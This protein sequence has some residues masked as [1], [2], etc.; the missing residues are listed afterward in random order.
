MTLT[1]GQFH[2]KLEAATVD[3][4]NNPL[5]GSTS[6]PKP[7]NAAGTVNNVN[8]EITFTDITY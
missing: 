2:F 4:E 7:S 1:D 8:G 6:I 3:E 5:S